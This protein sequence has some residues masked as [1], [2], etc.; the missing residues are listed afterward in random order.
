MLITILKNEG[1][2]WEKRKNK[3]VHSAYETI[4]WKLRRT[5]LYSFKYPVEYNRTHFLKRLKMETSVKCL[6][7]SK[8][9]FLSYVKRVCLLSRVFAFVCLSVHLSKV[10]YILI[11]FLHWYYLHCPYTAGDNSSCPWGS[12]TFTF[13]SPIMICTIGYFFSFFEGVRAGG[14]KPLN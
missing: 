14:K 13:H 10:L 1:K 3:K 8:Q 12:S 6:N 9:F 2:G 5:A 11:F 4:F 7:K